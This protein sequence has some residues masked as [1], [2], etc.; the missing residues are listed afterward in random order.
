MDLLR[1]RLKN[2]SQENQNHIDEKTDIVDIGID[3]RLRDVTLSRIRDLVEA[4]EEIELDIDIPKITEIDE[5]LNP[6]NHIEKYHEDDFLLRRALLVVHIDIDQDRNQRKNAVDEEQ[7]GI[8]RI[9]SKLVDGKKMSVDSKRD[10]HHGDNRHQHRN[11][12]NMVLE[13]DERSHQRKKK[14][15]RL[16]SIRQRHLIHVL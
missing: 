15:I 6:G 16:I 12:G 2:R 3:L 9:V 1:K 4:V 8:Q 5:N 11:D 10:H 13:L 14:T 7:K